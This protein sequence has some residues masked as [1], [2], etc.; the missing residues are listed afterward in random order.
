MHKEGSGHMQ[1]GK[2]TLLSI[3]CAALAAFVTPANAD[4]V[5]AGELVI[6]QA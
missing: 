4:E 2:L 5:K 3:A 6:T 1:I